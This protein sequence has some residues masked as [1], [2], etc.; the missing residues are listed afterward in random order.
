[1][2]RRPALRLFASGSLGGALGEVRGAAGFASSFLPS[3]SLGGAEGEVLLLVVFSSF[4]ASGNYFITSL[5]SY[6]S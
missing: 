6:C 3:G 1:M 2:L 5:I 4:F